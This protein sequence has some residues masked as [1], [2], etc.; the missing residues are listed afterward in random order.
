MGRVAR[1]YPTGRLYLRTPAKV[2]EEKL[3]PVY[4]S[5]FCGGKKIRQ[6]TNLMSMKKDWNQNANYGIGELRASFGS[7]YKKK[8]KRFKSFSEKLIVT[9]LTL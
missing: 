6:T 8:T 2:D 1:K 9:S 4:L 7:D 5:Y 3:Y